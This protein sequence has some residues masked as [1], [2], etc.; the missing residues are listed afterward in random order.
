MNTIDTQGL[1]N[2][3]AAW[4]RESRRYLRMARFC[5]SGGLLPT[6]PLH[7]Q[8]EAERLRNV[9]LSIRMER[10]TGVPHCSCSNPPHKRTDPP[11]TT[12]HFG[13]RW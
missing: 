9:A 13:G 10:E 12:C 8:R 1:R 5:A 2:A 4:L 6:N 3:E 7:C 11:S